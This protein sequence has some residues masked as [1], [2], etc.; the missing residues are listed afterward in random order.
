M[1]D[2]SSRPYL[3][4][5]EAL[6]EDIRQLDEIGKRLIAS[7]RGVRGER[8]KN[9][10]TK[11]GKLKTTELMAK[12]TTL[13]AQMDMLPQA[14]EDA[15]NKFFAAIDAADAAFVGRAKGL[16]SYIVSTGKANAGVSYLLEECKAYD[17]AKGD[18]K[19]RRA[20]HAVILDIM[21]SVA[22]ACEKEKSSSY[23]DVDV[24]FAQPVESPKSYPR[25]TFLEP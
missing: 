19:R 17:A 6:D 24:N 23:C 1:S 21:G 12:L 10:A 9:T 11:Q 13:Q 15:G 3:K 7:A 14:Y 20:M 22:D 5:C 18:F 4:A 16:C 8:P 25:V 2:L